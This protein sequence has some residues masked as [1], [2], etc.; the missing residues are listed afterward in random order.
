MDNPY[1]RKFRNRLLAWFVETKRDLPWRRTS[2]PYRILVSEIM[3]QQTQVTTSLDYYRR[4]I[5]RFPSVR[6]LAQASI[7]D[8]LKVWEGLGYYGRARNLHRAAGDVVQQHGGRIPDT[9]EALS[10][11]P[12]VGRYT[13]GAVLSIA[14]GKRVP[15]LDGNVIRVLSRVFRITENIDAPDVRKRLWILA[16]SLL[17]QKRIREFNESLMELGAV[18]CKSRNPRCPECPLASLC[19]AKAHSVQHEL[20]VRTPK[21]PIPHYHVTAGVIW[22]DGTFLITRRLPKGLLGGLWEFPGGKQ[23]KGETLKQCLAR[24]IREELNITIHVQDRLISVR[25]AYSHFKITLHVFRC[26]Y[27][28]GEIRLRGCDRY[29]WI[30]ADALDRFAFPGADRKVIHYLKNQEMLS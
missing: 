28:K 22:K 19:E 24:E 29:Q 2:D 10:S 21:K 15:V 1:K 4:F 3:L 30:T 25:H 26:R 20:P 23:E 12:G 16:E 6:K 14:F 11:L 7:D 18:V 5:R 27:R 17:P 8:V 13:A 9:L